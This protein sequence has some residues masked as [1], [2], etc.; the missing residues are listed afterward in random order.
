VGDPDDDEMTSSSRSRPPCRTGSTPLNAWELDR[1]VDIAMDALR[2]PRPGDAAVD[3][4]LR[5]REAPRRAVPLLLSEARPAPARRAH[6]PPRRRDGRLA[7]AHPARV[8][9]HRRSSSPTT[10]TSS[11]TSPSGSWSWRTARASRGRATTRSGSSQKRSASPRRSARASASARWPERARVGQARPRQAPGPQQGPP[12]AAYEQLLA[13]AEER[14]QEAARDHHPARP[15]PRRRRR[16]SFDHVSKG[17]GDR[18]LIDDLSFKLPRGGIVGIIGPNGAGKTTLFRMIVGQEQADSGTLTIG[19]TVQLSYVD[20][21]AQT[22]RRR[23]ERLGEHHRRRRGH[24]RI[25][26]REINSRA[27][28]GTFGFKGAGPAA[29]GRH[30]LGRRAQP[31]APREAAADRRQPAAARRAHQRPRRRHA[32]RPRRGPGGLRR[33]RGHH[34]PRSL[35]PRPHRHPHPRLRGRQQVVWFEGNYEAYEP[36]ASAPRASTPTSPTA[37]STS[38][39]LCKALG[40]RT[41]VGRAAPR[42]SRPTT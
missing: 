13:R 29:E 2:V 39:T 26:K 7:G 3:P 10:A 21:S 37:S 18:L 1:T 19:E 4:P 38:P 22:P 5:R 31:R 23:Q 16:R 30:P 41:L 33:L 42:S 36:T 20:Q 25:G 28:C 9:R 40:V 17:Y 15:A 27:Y 12:Q 11:T 24:R 32:A 35:V 14:R 34:Q 6:Q 8:P